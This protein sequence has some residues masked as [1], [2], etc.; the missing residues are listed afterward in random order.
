MNN[1]FM[2]KPIS[3]VDFARSERVPSVSHI[4]MFISDIRDACVCV[5]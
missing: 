1:H 2:H 4:I 5:F 3:H